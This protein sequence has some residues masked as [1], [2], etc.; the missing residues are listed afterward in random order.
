MT[1]TGRFSL[2]SFFQCIFQEAYITTRY[3]AFLTICRSDAIDILDLKIG[4]SRYINKYAINILGEEEHAELS[5]DNRKEI[6]QQEEIIATSPIYSSTDTSS[7]I[8]AVA[9]VFCITCSGELIIIKRY[10]M[11]ISLFKRRLSPKFLNNTWY[12]E[13]TFAT[14]PYSGRQNIGVIKAESCSHAPYE[15]N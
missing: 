12:L 3:Y 13:A 7:P 4:S 2:W 14:N 9:A 8:T 6:A 11:I 1:L 15:K 5:E 10:A